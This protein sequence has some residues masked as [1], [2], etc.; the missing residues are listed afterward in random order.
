VTIV[1]NTAEIRPD[2]VAVNKR[3]AAR[4]LAETQALRHALA[5]VET[6]R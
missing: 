1:E 3:A 2:K 5:E 6:Q 4:L